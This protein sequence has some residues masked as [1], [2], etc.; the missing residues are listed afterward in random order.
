VATVSGGTT[1]KR[2]RF[3]QEHARRLGVAY[4]CRWLKVPRSG[5]YDWRERSESDRSIQDQKLTVKITQI[6]AANRDVYGS[7]RVHKALKNQGVFVGRKR[8]ERLMRE[9]NLV[10]RLT[11]VVRRKAGISAFHRGGENKLLDAGSTTRINQVWVGD[12]TYLKVKDQWF[13]LAAIMDRHS[14][15]IISWTLSKPRTADVTVGILKRALRTRGPLNGLLFHSDRGI[16][17]TAHKYRNELKRHG[18]EISVNRPGHCADNAHMESFF[19][20]LKA[21]LIRG[22]GFTQ[23]ASYDMLSTVTLIVFIV[24]GGCIQVSVT[25][26]QLNMNK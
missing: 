1:S 21:E 17:Y 18:V 7:P 22:E 13:H 14:R 3:V 9:A 6:H 8:V 24:T 20:S 4:L 25:A 16:E 12:I 26:R 5:Y 15:R 23:C 19:H 11:K 2:Y 10:A